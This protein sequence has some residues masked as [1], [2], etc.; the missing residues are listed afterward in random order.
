MTYSEKSPMEEVLDKLGPPSKMLE[1]MN[2]EAPSIDS[3]ITREL[4]THPMSRHQ[5]DQF[6]A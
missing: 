2:K 4:S 3:L 6:S 1:Q 5:N